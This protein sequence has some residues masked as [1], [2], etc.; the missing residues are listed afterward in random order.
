MAGFVISKASENRRKGILVV[1]QMAAV[2]V[3]LVS[4]FAAYF[5]VFDP[6]VEAGC[7]MYP[8]MMWLFILAVV[9][10]ARILLFQSKHPGRRI[11]LLIFIAGIFAAVWRELILNGIAPFVNAYIEQRNQFYHIEQPGMEQSP[12]TLGYL[13]VLTGI[14]VLIGL[15]LTAVLK[16]ERGG[17]LTFIVMLIPVILAATVGHMPSDMASWALIAAGILYLI[18]YHGK[19]EIPSMSGIAMAAGVLVI[20][21]GCGR[22]VLPQ[23]ESYKQEHQQEYDEIKDRIIESQ[24][25]DIKAMIEDKIET[26]GDYAKGG[27]GEGDLKELSGY[28]PQGTKEM[29][30]T[31]TEFPE[32]TVYLKAFVG[33]AYNGS[34]W[35]EL[36]SSQFSEVISPIMGGVKRRDLLNEPFTRI[37]NGIGNLEEQQMEIHITGASAAYGYVPYYAEVPE[38]DSVKMDACVEGKN[39]KTREYRYYSRK[40]AE[41]LERNELAEESELWKSY[42]DFVQKTYIEYP[43]ELER[44]AEF[45][46]SMEGASVDEVAGEIDRRFAS[47]LSY[48]LNPGQKASDQDFVEYF[49]FEN[50]KGFCVHF[51]SAATLIYRECGYP[52]RYVEGYAVSP[53]EFTEQGDGTYKAVVT[54]AMAHAWCETFD[55][56]TGWMV[57]EHTLPYQDGSYAV[58]DEQPDQTEQGT[59]NTASDETGS[60]NNESVTGDLKNKMENTVDNTEKTGDKGGEDGSISNS[61]NG[62]ADSRRKSTVVIKAAGMT[63]AAFLG[64][65]LILL[66]CVMQQKVRR[67]KKL[68]CF[69]VK[70]ENRGIAAMYDEVYELCIFMGMERKKQT[71]RETL[72]QMKK[73][74]SQLTDEEWEWMYDCAVRAAFTKEIIGREEQKQFYN[75]Y[76]KLRKEILK[77]LKGRKRFWFLYGKGM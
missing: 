17:I 51:A 53:E 30:V 8:S 18:V 41:R 38:G 63:G 35:E 24:Q 69:R 26:A 57:R 5:S 49:L 58:E 12:D 36:K 65:A 60:G 16:A 1:V 52:A 10:V 31:V 21:Y 43:G 70:R 39:K 40:Q 54:D 33:S 2:Y 75:L 14:Q 62:G 7:R 29:E 48:T 72:E 22:V 68:Y 71:D 25:V 61:E 67:Q 3:V 19:N 13:V 20:L 64:A 76:R 74:F 37:V 73:S 56:E 66:L 77:G 50:Q 27:I 23:I 32:S 9:C 15:I 46:S 4:V 47:D 59:E 44:L 34:K 55:S 6:E 42:R 11:V 28:H 45:C